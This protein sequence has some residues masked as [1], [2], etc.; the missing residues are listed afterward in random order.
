LRLF[1]LIGCLFV[2]ALAQQSDAAHTEI[3]LQQQ[4]AQHRDSYQANHNL[5]EFYAQRK[6]YGAAVV[7]LERA[8]QIDPSNYENAYDLALSQLLGGNLSSARGLVKQ[9]LGLSD[10]AELHNLNAA[11]E[12]ASGNFREAA[13]EFQTAASMDPSPKNLFDLGTELLKYHGY[14]QAVEIFRYAVNKYPEAAQ[15]RVGLG[16]AQYS[17]GNYRDAV[18]TLC[19]AVDLD[20]KDTRALD[21]LGKMY[22]VAPELSAEVTKNL[23]RFATLY[24]QNAAANYYY[25]LALTNPVLPG[26]PASKAQAMHLLKKAT[27]EDPGFA[28]AH[29]QLALAYADSGM[30]VDAIKE[31]KLAVKLRSNFKSAHYRLAQLYAKHGE[32]ELANR[33][34]AAVKSLNT[35]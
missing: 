29:Y 13:K 9:L 1:F 16:V 4:L 10:R 35:P 22:D 8:Y 15:L 17:L 23:K 26:D 11:I 3:R 14:R 2:P 12:E 19:H 32:T 34:Y 18:E 7:Y 28:D 6:N 27:T 30:D 25:A 24:P 21:F 31:L 5:G 20:P 33:E